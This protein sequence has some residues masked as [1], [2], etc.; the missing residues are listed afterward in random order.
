MLVPS[1]KNILLALIISAFVLPAFAASKGDFKTSKEYV[2]LYDLVSK[3]KKYKNKK[4][5]IEGEFFSFSSLA[6]D[7]PKAERSSDDYLGI[8]LSRPDK[9][10]IPLVEAKFAFPLKAFRKDED[11]SHIEHGDLIHVTGKVFAIELGEPWIDIKS[12]E[13][14][15]KVEKEEELES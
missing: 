8:L 15:K 13:I 9:E 2:T 5:K 3:P 10:E 6:L 1:Y 14:V 7:Y 12:I 11:L 4:V